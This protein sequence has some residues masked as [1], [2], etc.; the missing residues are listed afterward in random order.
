M[1]WLLG[2]TTCCGICSRGSNISVMVFTTER[3]YRVLQSGVQIRGGVLF[4]IIFVRLQR[5]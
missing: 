2:S 4:I 3:G 1:P 5:A